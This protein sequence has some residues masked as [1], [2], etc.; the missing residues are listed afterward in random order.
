M[1]PVKRQWISVGA[2]LSAAVLMFGLAG[3]AAAAAIEQLREFASG[4]RSAQ[5]EFTQRTFKQSGQAAE[6]TSG[7]FAFARPGRFRWEVRKPFEQLMVADGDQLHFFDKDLN[8]VTVRKLSDAAGATPAA[9]LFGD[10]DLEKTFILK[11]NGSRDG[12]D[13]LEA[14]PRSKESGFDR[15]AIG[16][17]GGLPES[18]E[19]IDA[20][21]RRTVFGFRSV[22][23][24]PRLDDATFRFVPPPGA[25]VVRQ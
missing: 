22:Q 24:N 11:E 14:L 17:R 12:L 16:L 25:D 23:R 6:S 8:Q 19:V 21:G 9:I 18:M 1:N 20:F 13:W 5:G 10:G 7:T 3:P 15:I 4:T 2:A